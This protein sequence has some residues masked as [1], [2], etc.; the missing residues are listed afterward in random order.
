[1]KSLFQA[2]K[3]SPV[4]LNGGMKSWKWCSLV[5][6]LTMAAGCGH[7]KNSNKSIPAARLGSLRRNFSRLP[8]QRL[9]F[10]HCEVKPLNLYGLII[11]S[12]V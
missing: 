10:P 9:R 11:G 4:S 1:M 12:W 8:Q 5:F 3:I 7:V 2:E 6:A